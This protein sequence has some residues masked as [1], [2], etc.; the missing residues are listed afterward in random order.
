MFQVETIHVKDLDGPK[1]LVNLT[2]RLMRKGYNR[3][4][5]EKILSGN[6]LRVFKQ[7]WGQ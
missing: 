6:F 5:L 7:V 4:D 1:D 2:E 3:N